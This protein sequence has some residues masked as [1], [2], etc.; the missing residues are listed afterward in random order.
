[1]PPTP[2]CAPSRGDLGASSAALAGVLTLAGRFLSGRVLFRPAGAFDSTYTQWAVP[3]DPASAR[4]MRGVPRSQWARQPG[5]QRQVARLLAVA[6]VVMCLVSPFAAGVTFGLVAVGALAGLQ[7]GR[8]HARQDEAPVGPWGP[9]GAAQG[10]V[11]G[12]W[13]ASGYSPPL[14]P[15]VAWQAVPHPP[16]GPGPQTWGP[17]PYSIPESDP[18]GP[19]TVS[20]WRADRPYGGA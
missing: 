9:P 10:A 14:D 12:P 5:W 16:Y 11:Y 6:L 8:N 4:A 2:L 1:M 17:H 20:A 15:R 19:M 7:S 18:P 13:A 3:L